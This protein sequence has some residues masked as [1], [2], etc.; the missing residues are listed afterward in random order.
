MTDETDERTRIPGKPAALKHVASY[1]AQGMKPG[2]LYEST[3]LSYGGLTSAEVRR[4][5]WA[6][7]EVRR[8]LLKMAGE[9]AE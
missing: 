2:D 3:G 8:R 9:P 1:M 5:E 4:L 6:I 7:G